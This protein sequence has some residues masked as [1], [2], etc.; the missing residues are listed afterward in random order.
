[1]RETRQQ[2]RARQMEER[3]KQR[4]QQA[5]TQLRRRRVTRVGL[6]SF[7]LLVGVGV[8]YGGYSIVAD[9][10]ASQ[11]PEGVDTT[12]NI[13]SSHSEE[14]I[15]YGEGL[16]PVGG[17][18]A[19]SRVQPCA[20]YDSQV[21]TELA[22]HS[23]EHGAIWITFLPDLPGEEVATLREYAD[24]SKVLVSPYPGQPSDVVVT[25][26]GNQLEV[27]SASDP[28]IEQFIRAFRGSRGDAPEP[29]AQC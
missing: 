28:D 1:M 19:G 11:P 24:Q 16:P 17:T 14:P 15:D 8:V 18:H 25:A 7:A 21:P 23:L 10:R 26:W 13:A 22:V 2:R 27:A 12:T 5:N 3:R 29:N 6:I 4:R 20:F 9:W